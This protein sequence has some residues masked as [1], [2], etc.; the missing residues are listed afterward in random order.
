[1]NW[2]QKARFMHNASSRRVKTFQYYVQSASFSSHETQIKS[3]MV[4]RFDQHLLH[5]RA[6]RLPDT[7]Q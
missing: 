5:N 4:W 6:L 2:K 7:R 3:G 1:M